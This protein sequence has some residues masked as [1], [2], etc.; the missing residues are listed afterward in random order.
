M[1]RYFVLTALLAFGCGDKSGSGGN[2]MAMNGGTGPDLAP[3]ADMTDTTMP[4]APNATHV[5]ATGPTAG[6]VTAGVKAAAYLLNP[7]GTPATGELHVVTAAG[8]DKKIDTG[9]AIGGYALTNDGK[10]VIYTKPSGQNASLFWADASA[11]TVTPKTLFTGTYPSAT[12]TQGGFMAP[13]GHY[14]LAGVRGAGV[15]QSLDMHVINMANGNDVYQRLNGGFDYLEVVLPDDTCIFQDTAG[16]TSTTT[17]PVQTL[18][19]ISLPMAATTTA[20]AINTRTANMTPT[21]DNKTLLYLKSNGDLYAWDLTTKTG[22][23][24]KIASAV[25]KYAVGGDATGPVAF[26]AADGSVHVQ[27][28]KGTKL[29]DTQPSMATSFRAPIALAPDGADLYFFQNGDLVTGGVQN[30]Q[31]TLMRVAVQAGATP[32]KVADKVSIKDLQVMDNALVFVQNVDGTGT[33]GD[34][35]K[36]NRDG[37][38]ISALGMKVP[39]G[40]LQVVNPGPDTWFAMHLTM[41]VNDTANA[42]I[43][44]SPAIYGALAWAD[45]NG[46]AEQTLDGKVHA[47][48]FGF[49]LDDGRTAAFV[50]GA[51]FNATAKNY[52]GALAFLAARAPST[53]IDGKLSGVSELGPIIGR[54]L[55]VNAPTATTAGV[56]FVTY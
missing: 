11:A 28:T 27:S 18:Y 10:Q 9:V 50:T 37:S 23:G 30:N 14:F 38:G 55:F 56:Y 7:T 13:S 40:G 47:G 2:D 32:S 46:G 52:V 17:P 24:S 39:V 35:A 48:T 54:S 16:G 6:L 25:V 36:A 15:A 29:L 3:P 26:I 19:W 20:A 33:F 43:D 21:A 1:T 42:P 31:G 45:Y 51:T 8:V 44:G 5:G 41:S 4:P 22:A 12:L 34:A 49:A 53:K